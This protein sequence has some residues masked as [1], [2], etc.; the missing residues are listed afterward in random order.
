[1]NKLYRNTTITF[2][3]LIIILLILIV[4]DFF[5]GSAEISFLDFRNWISGSLSTD[6][7]TLIIIRE[8]RVSRILIALLAG[9]ALSVSGLL[10]Q[11]IFH[12]PLAGPYVLGISS[13]AGLGVALLVLGVGG[14]LPT[15]SFGFSSGIIVFA[16]ALGAALVMLLILLASLKIKDIFYI[17]ILGI[18]I[19][20]AVS[21]IVNLLQFFAKDINVKSFVVWGMGSLYAVSFNEIIIIVPIILATIISIMFFSKSLN[22]LLLGEDY[23]QTSGVNIKALRIAVF[24]ATSILAGTI[25]AYCGPIGFIGVAAPHITRWIFRSANHFVLIPGSLI[26]GAQIMLVG[27]LISHIWLSKGILPINAVTALIGIPFIIYLVLNTRK[28]SV[29]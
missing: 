20:A 12:N 7:N 28:T 25:T 4:C 11:T 16:A 6:K 1:M 17:L 5:T 8:F 10:M 15:L 14:V 21:A 9:A 19:G 29:K 13:G 26:I 18:L 23:A 2:V 22:L 3:L 24:V 27:D